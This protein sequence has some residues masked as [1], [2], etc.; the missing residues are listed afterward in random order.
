M[1]VS[2]NTTSNSSSGTVSSAGLATN[3]DV[4]SIVSA[5]VGSEISSKK[6]RLESTQ[7]GDQA[8]ISALGS[9]TST[10]STLRDAI[11][12][13]TLDGALSS[14]SAQSG[15]SAVLTATASSGAIAASH[16]IEVQ[17]L[18]QANAIGSSAYASADAEVGTGTITINAGGSSFDVTLAS[19]ADSLVELRDAINNAPNNTGVT[20]TIVTGND[21]AHLLLSATGTGTA[22]AVSV[23]SPL[24]SFS[25]V[26]SAADASIVVDGYSYTS[27]SNTISDAIEGLTLDLVAAKPG[28]KLSLRVAADTA[29][30]QSAIQSFVDAY[31]AA[32]DL[33]NTDTHYDAST[34]EAGPL[35]GNT[36]VVSLGQRLQTLVSTALGSAVGGAS[37]LTDIGISSDANGKL[38][39]DPTRLGAALTNNS[40][41]VQAL[42]SRGSSPAFQMGS[43]LRGYLGIGGIIGSQT[44][45]L[46]SELDDISTQLTALSTRSDT[47]TALYTSKFNAINTQVSSYNNLSSYMTQLMQSLLKSTS[48]SS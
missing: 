5:I 32:L 38:T 46:Q 10:L 31:N 16:E 42:L 15:D 35:L 1:S 27:S 9:L 37:T 34:Q 28:T 48:S 3:L 44:D 23:S 17:T 7:A 25:S 29:S 18:A 36:A 6:T 24:I 22:N 45:G 4:S 12:H 26:R 2:L 14:L 11:E 30:A 21:G 13:M 43:L 41:G 47:L 8:T 20:A 39:V 40:A 33:V 19:G